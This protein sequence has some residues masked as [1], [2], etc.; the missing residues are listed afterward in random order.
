MRGRGLCRLFVGRGR[1]L[2][3]GD[4][5]PAPSYG[6]TAVVCEVL[7]V[8]L[9]RCL[10]LFALLGVGTGDLMGCVKQG[11][12]FRP[13]VVQEVQFVRFGGVDFPI[14]VRHG[15]VPAT[16]A[17]NVLLHLVQ[18]SFQGVLQ[19]GVR[20]VGHLQIQAAPAE[21]RSLCRDSVAWVASCCTMCS[22]A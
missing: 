3:L 11:L 22:R 8:G 6:Q 17:V 18:G 15:S 2:E 12:V 19:V 1:L 7:L 14:V 5:S 4:D 9:A 16:G 10:P 13:L 20:Q 21:R